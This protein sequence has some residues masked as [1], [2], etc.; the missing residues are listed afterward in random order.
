ML[1]A[2]RNDAI[3]RAVVHPSSTL[4]A[5]GSAHEVI[6][7]DPLWLNIS[8]KAGGIGDGD[9]SGKAGELQS[10]CNSWLLIKS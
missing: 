3:S 2:T 9:A 8:N 10:I 5:F 4:I 1:A 7:L 6:L